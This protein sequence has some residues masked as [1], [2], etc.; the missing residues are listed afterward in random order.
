MCQINNCMRNSFTA[1]M[2]L[3]KCAMSALFVPGLYYSFNF[4]MSPPIRRRNHV[5]PSDGILLCSSRKKMNRGLLLLASS[6]MLDHGI[7][8]AS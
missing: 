7:A 2:Y 5:S 8:R 6:R 3:S 1:A 4:S